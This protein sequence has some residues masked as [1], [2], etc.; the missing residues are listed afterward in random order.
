MLLSK[1]SVWVEAS[2]AVEH[3]LYKMGAPFV[4]DEIL[5]Q[6]IFPT[7]DLKFLNDRGKYTRNVGGKKVKETIFGKPKLK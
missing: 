6:D 5:A 3:V 1:N 2:E 4:D 7:A